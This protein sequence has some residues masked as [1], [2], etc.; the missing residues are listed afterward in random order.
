MEAELARVVQENKVVSYS[1][2]ILLNF[3]ETIL[4]FKA[5]DNNPN[6]EGVIESFVYTA[7]CMIGIAREPL[8]KGFFLSLKGIIGL[9]TSEEGMNRSTKQSMLLSPIAAKCLLEHR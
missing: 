6:G 2:K 5:A 9:K 8:I 1:D 4:Q 3:F 7:D